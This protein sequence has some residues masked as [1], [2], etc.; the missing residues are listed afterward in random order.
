MAT[1]CLGL[2]NTYLCYTACGTDYYFAYII[3][4][5][6]CSNV[7]TG[8]QHS[9]LIYSWLHRYCT[10]SSVHRLYHI[11]SHKFSSWPACMMLSYAIKMLL[12]Q[13]EKSVFE[14]RN[15]AGRLSHGVNLVTQ[16]SLPCPFLQITLYFQSISKFNSLLMEIITPHIYIY[17]YTYKA[18]SCTSCHE[19]SVR[20]P[21]SSPRIITIAVGLLQVRGC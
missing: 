19:T 13:I 16:Y 2:H 7:C 6:R 14:H 21:T 15:L 8:V 3:L 4:P 12:K 9:Y 18:T 17:I 11:A 5:E 1:A 10:H 20:P